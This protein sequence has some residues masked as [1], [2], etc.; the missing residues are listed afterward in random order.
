LID[1]SLKNGVVDVKRQGDWIILLKL[2][3]ADLVLNTISV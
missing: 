2:V 1:K 3:I